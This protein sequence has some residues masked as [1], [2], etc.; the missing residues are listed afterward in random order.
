[1]KEKYFILWLIIDKPH[2]NL[3]FQ[4]IPLHSEDTCLG[5]DRIE[6]PLYDFVFYLATG[7]LM[8]QQIFLNMT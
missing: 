1:M 7:L 4:G 3:L 2:P 6:V 5:P 8:E